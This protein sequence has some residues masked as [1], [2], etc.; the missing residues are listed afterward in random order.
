MVTTGRWSELERL[1]GKQDPEA[2][3]MTLP[4]IGRQTARK[5]HTELHVDTLMEL[6]EAADDGRLEHLPEFG[7]RSVA[8]VRAA[9][10]ERLRSLRGHVRR[11]RPPHVSLLLEI[12]ELYRSKARRNELKLIAPPPETDQKFQ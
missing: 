1:T 2:L 6:E 9:L 11:G 5:L 7:E 4:G 12:D 10:K 3:L 8:A